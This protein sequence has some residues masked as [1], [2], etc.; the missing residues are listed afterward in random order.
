MLARWFAKTY[1]CLTAPDAAEAMK[2]LAANPDTALMISDFKMP[3]ESGL[4]LAKKAKAAYPNLAVI[5]LTAYADVNLVIE[6][7]RDGVDDFFQKPVTNLSQLEL[8]MTKALRTAALEKEVSD[9]KSQLGGELE[10]FTG[11]SPAMERVYHLIRKVAPTDANVLIEGPSGTGKELAARAIHNLS[12]RSRGPFV[13]V[14]CAALSSTLLES[15]LFGHEKGAFTDAHAQRIGKFELASGGTLFLDE[16]GELP[17]EAQGL[18]LRV[19]EEGRFQ[20]MGENAREV[21]VDVRVIA[22]TNRDLP[23][24]VRDG[25]FRLDLFQ[26]LSVIQ[27]RVPALREHKEDIPLIS[28][29]YRERN[30]MGG[31]LTQSQIEAL[32]SYDFPGNVRELYNLLERAYVLGVTDFRQLVR[33]HRELNAALLSKEAVEVPDNLEEVTRLHVKRVVEKY[34]G[35]ITKAA[36]ALGTSR[37]TVRKYQSP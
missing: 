4:D 13:A 21:E 19:L 6:A 26:R 10:N 24:M 22:A 17:L 33:E 25:K 1:N 9:L 37:N 3:G 34:N 29:S 32:Q 18:L 7:L 15:E 16:V 35:N 36:E 30:K 20:R 12:K 27:L 5:I 8:R 11:R 31:R 28:Y 14:E 2:V 23:S